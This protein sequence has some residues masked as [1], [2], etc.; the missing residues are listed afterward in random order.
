MSEHFKNRVD[1]T[2][3]EHLKKRDSKKNIEPSE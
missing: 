1:S 2:V 3:F